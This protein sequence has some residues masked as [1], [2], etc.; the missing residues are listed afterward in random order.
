[1]SDERT[2]SVDPYENLDEYDVWPGD[3]VSYIPSEDQVVRDN[4]PFVCLNK[5]GIVQNVHSS[6]RTANIRWFLPCHIVINEA[7]FLKDRDVVDG[8]MNIVS[9]HFNLCLLHRRETNRVGNRLLEAVHTDFSNIGRP[10]Y[11]R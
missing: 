7:E 11:Q 5:V 10:D 4:K 9:E 2:I 6:K 1:M 8:S 3:R